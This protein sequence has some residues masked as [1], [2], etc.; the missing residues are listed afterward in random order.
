M[1]LTRIAQS[2]NSLI[3]NSLTVNVK[4]LHSQKK[5]TDKTDKP[6]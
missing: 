6:F 1:Q 3:A 4:Q 2:L 5:A